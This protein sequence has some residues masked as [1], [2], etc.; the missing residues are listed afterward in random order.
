M[1]SK[2][3][4]KC[5]KRCFKKCGS[6]CNCTSAEIMVGITTQYIGG[7][8]SLDQMIT[9]IDDYLSFLTTQMGQ[10]D[11]TTTVETILDEILCDRVQECVEIP[12]PIDLCAAFTQCA[13]PKVSATT[14]SDS[15]I[16]YEYLG[17]SWVIYPPST[18]KPTSQVNPDG[19]V[20]YTLNG[21]SWTIRPPVIPSLICE[22]NGDGSQTC[23]YNEEIS[24]TTSTEDDKICKEI[25]EN[26]QVGG[27]LLDGNEVKLQ[28]T[29]PAGISPLSGSITIGG[30]EIPLTLVEG[31]N[32]VPISNV[33][34][35][36]TS[37]S[38]ILEITF[39]DGCIF[40]TIVENPYMGRE[41][42]GYYKLE[43]SDLLNPP[44]L[45]SQDILNYIANNPIIHNTP[46]FYYQGDEGDVDKYWITFQ[47]VPYLLGKCNCCPKGGQA[48][49]YNNPLNLF[50]NDPQLLVVN[51]SGMDAT[52]VEVQFTSLGSGVVIEP[53]FTLATGTNT[54]L[55]PSEVNWALLPVKVTFTYSNG[56]QEVIAVQA[57]RPFPPVDNKLV[58]TNLT[59]NTYT[60]NPAPLVGTI[61]DIY[62]NGLLLTEGVDYTI[63]SGTVTFTS[64]LI[65]TDTLT[66]RYKTNT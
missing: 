49:W 41:E 12:E 59:G 47:G 46:I 32:Q 62:K 9:N 42:I 29:I 35:I 66:I 50:G 17:V 27:Y 34:Y 36:N 52:S 61:V 40:T 43:D 37:G 55:T 1:G 58:V 26:V 38:D 44:N 3:N 20:T 65:A 6:K 18:V 48:V 57:M 22:D 14:N 4:K 53:V 54:T 51:E 21:V 25:R 8:V 30:V 23:T 10:G 33:D 13:L 31:D 24:W 45:T 11:V 63:F 64:T 5:P 15:S 56:C 60:I 7:E 2:C 28:I 39:P 19:S 16:T